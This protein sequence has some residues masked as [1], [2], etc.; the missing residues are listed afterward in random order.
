[1]FVVTVSFQIYPEQIE[2]FMPDMLANAKASVKLEEN[3]LQFDVCQSKDSPHMVFLYEVYR[4]QEDFKQHMS[5][6][7]FLDFNSK[8]QAMVQSKSVHTFTLAGDFRKSI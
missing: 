6:P 5:M 8:T 1:M 7:H 4:S 2:R 3:C